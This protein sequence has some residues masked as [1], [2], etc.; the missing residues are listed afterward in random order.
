MVGVGGG[1]QPID[2]LRGDLEGRRETEG[3]IGADNVVVN[4]LGQVQDVEP[5]LGKL[6]SILGSTTATQGDQRVESELLVVLDDGG[7]HVLFLTINDHAIDLVTAGSE[8]GSADRQ[9][10]GEGARIQGDRPILGQ[11]EEAVLNTDQL[12]VVL[13]NGCL[14][15][16]TDRGIETWA[17]T[18]SGED[19]DLLLLGHDDS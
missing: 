5:G 7:D 13:P 18:T 1:V 12:H 11:P 17:V 14:A 8:N 9:D 3:V 4:G 10:A 16:S 15:K 19:A 2:R 6:V